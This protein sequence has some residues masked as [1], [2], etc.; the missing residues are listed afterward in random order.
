MT[1]ITDVMVDLE[2]L[3]TTPGSVVLSI[4]AVAFNKQEVFD[5]TFY[6]EINTDSSYSYD[7]TSCPKT[8]KWWDE[9]GADARKTLSNCN[10]GSVDELDVVL[11]GFKRFLAVNPDVRFWGNGAAFDNVILA[12]A[13]EATGIK[14]PWK[15][16]ND[17]CYRTL[18][19]LYPNV[20]LQRTGTHHNALD[21]AITQAKHAVAIFQS[22]K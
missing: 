21:D 6:A 19:G 22:M 17:R 5:H 4:G 3:G 1:F 8:L 9:Q 10:E 12:A 14:L 13:Y 16:W 18:K 11:T 20:P 2:T 7:M 15:F